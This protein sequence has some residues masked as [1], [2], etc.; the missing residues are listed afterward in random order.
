M[1]LRVALPVPLF[2]E[3]DYL[4]PKDTP[5]SRLKIGARIKVPF[6]KRNLIGVITANQIKSKLPKSKLKYACEVWDETPLLASEIF[7]LC[8]WLSVYYHAPLGEVL[9]LAIPVPLRKKKQFNL[10]KNYSYKSL[11]SQD[12]TQLLKRAPKQLALLRFIQKHSHVDEIALGKNFPAWQIPLSKLVEKKLVVKNQVARAK[13][14]AQD[15]AK[16]LNH[17]QQAAL[18]GIGLTKYSC[19][20][21]YGVTGSG[22]TEIYLQLID[23]V[24]QAGKQALVLIPEISLSPQTLSRF[25][26][27]F[28]VLVCNQHSKLSDGQKYRSWLDSKNGKAKVLIATRSGIFNQFRNLGLII[29]DEEHDASFKQ[30]DGIRY[31]AR[32]LAIVRA[33]NLNIPIVLGSATPSLESLHNAWR[34]DYVFFSLRQRANK[35]QAPKL[36]LENLAINATDDIFTAYSLEQIKQTLQRNLQAMVFINRRGYA[37]V[38]YCNSCRHIKKCSRCDAH[39]V[40][41][42]KPARL[43]CHHCGSVA[44]PDA[45]CDNCGSDQLLMLGYG[46]AR[47]EKRLQEVLSQEKIIRIDR[48]TAGK[49]EAWDKLYQD[50]TTDKPCVL[51]GTQMLA[52]GHHFP[53]VALVVVMDADQGLLNTDFRASEHL[54]QLITQVA[55]RAGREKHQ[56]RVILQTFQ[57]D[58]K[59]LKTLLAEGYLAVAKMLLAER[60]QAGFPPITAMALIR[61]ESHKAKLAGN[62]LGAI[63]NLIDDKRVEKMGPLPAVMGK[64]AGKYR[65]Q[66]VLQA[67]NKRIIQ[68]CLARL[69][70]QITLLKDHSRL[71]WNVDVDPINML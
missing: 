30:Q 45:T 6:G 9:Q 1:H 61:A 63:K 51:I 41:H 60:A 48:D 65:Y 44:S 68:S 7:K 20:L 18:D 34:H 36:R 54:S 25:R 47:V 12:Q 67:E 57:P 71:R 31:S 62:F 5:I 8:K 17:E 10:I 39:M 33:K 26:Q 43:I 11:A 32:D 59:V 49:R 13:T 35:A 3:F 29:V 37:P 69:V 70:P 2:K 21:I 55:G 22:K 14:K 50:I 58:N 23:K 16:K 40:L 42:Q 64:L 38:F 28:E 24:I 27:R 52:K 56:G 19:N 46:T 15:N 53:N 4:P 66:L